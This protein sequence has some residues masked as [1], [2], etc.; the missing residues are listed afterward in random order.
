MFIA[1]GPLSLCMGSTATY[2]C[3]AAVMCPRYPWNSLN[4]LIFPTI[5]QQAV[6]MH[7]DDIT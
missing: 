2:E 1:V 5:E 6:T 7:Y 4:Y 3:I